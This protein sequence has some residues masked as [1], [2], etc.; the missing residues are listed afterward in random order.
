MSTADSQHLFINSA[1]GQLLQF[2]TQTMSDYKTYVFKDIVS[3]LQITK[4]DKYM[5]A[6]THGGEFFVFDLSL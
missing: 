2:N 6:C 5:Y 3:C 4:D 1:D